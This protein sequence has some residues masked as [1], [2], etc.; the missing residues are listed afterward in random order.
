MTRTKLPNVLFVQR[1]FSKNYMDSVSR[2][3][4]IACGRAN[5][6]LVN[7]GSS[8]PSDTNTIIQN[9]EI[10]IADVSYAEPNV[11]Y[12]VGGAATI[13]KPIILIADGSRTIP[14][15]L[16]RFNSL[17]YSSLSAD[18]FSEKLAQKIRQALSEPKEF[19]FYSEKSDDLKER[20]VFISY[21]HNDRMYM[22]RLMVHLKPL[23][24]RKIIE[25]WADTKLKAGDTWKEE[26]TKA[27][28][29]ATVAII[30]VSADFL[31][32]DFIVDNELPPLLINAEVNGTRIIPLIVK[33]CRFARD[34]NLRHFQSINDP[35]KALIKLTEAEQ[36]SCYD[37][38]AR[39][40]EQ[41]VK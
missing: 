34:E 9:C 40:V 33:P 19:T 23:E 6:N 24:K 35:N 39:E 21:S 18:E 1:N 38:V 20:R 27:L 13:N 41:M 11:L 37:D 30:L 14:L 15:D 26:I 2:I 10:V 7:F 17:V 25:L 22:E 12:L 4:A 29:K 16:A 36:E 31:A 3:V 8:I 5:V 28:N 32:S